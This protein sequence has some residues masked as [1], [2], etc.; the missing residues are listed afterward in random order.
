MLQDIVI[1][2]MESSFSLALVLVLVLLASNCK[3][4]G[5]QNSDAVEPSENQLIG[6]LW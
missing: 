3:N 5:A 1:A 4:T 6:K 2:E